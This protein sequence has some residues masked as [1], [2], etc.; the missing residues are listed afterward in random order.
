MVEEKG[1]TVVKWEHM[2]RGSGRVQTKH[3]Y[4][5]RQGHKERGGEEQRKREKKEERGAKK[6]KRVHRKQDCE[7]CSDQVYRNE[8]TEE[9]KK[10]SWLERF[11]VVAG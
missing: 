1:F 4:H 6:T 10:S 8:R 5:I 7:N 9:G 2:A 11:R 3:C